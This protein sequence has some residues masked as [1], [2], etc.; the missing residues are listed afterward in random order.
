MDDLR[1][2][3]LI[4]T[5]AEADTAEGKAQLERQSPLNSAAQIKTPLMVVQG[6]NDPRVNVAYASKDAEA[7]ADLYEDDAIYANPANG[8]TVVGRAAIIEKL[9]EMFSITLKAVNNAEVTACDSSLPLKP[10]ARSDSR[11]RSNAVGSRPRCRRCSARIASLTAGV[12][13]STKKISSNL[14]LRSSSGGRLEM[15]FAEAQTSA[16]VRMM[17]RAY[18]RTE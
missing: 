9:N 10:S 12:G 3:V 16:S 6:A 14:P 8:W 1:A 5:K 4:D 17:L 13:R 2:L 18:S 7:I 11:G 15:S